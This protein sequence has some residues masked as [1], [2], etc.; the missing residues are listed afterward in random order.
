M[1][2]PGSDAPA[3]CADEGDAP[4]PCVGV[5]AA[6]VAAAVGDVTPSTPC[7]SLPPLLLRRPLP[8]P[9]AAS[10]PC[11]SSPSFLPRRLLFLSS[12]GA[13]ITTSMAEGLT[14]GGSRSPSPAS[15]LR[16]LSCCQASNASWSLPYRCLRTSLF[17]ARNALISSSLRCVKKG[18]RGALSA[19]DEAGPS[20]VAEYEGS[21]ETWIWSCCSRNCCLAS[22]LSSSRSSSS[23]FCRRL[24]CMK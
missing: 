15:L 6:A 19:S 18:S 5:A 2:V 11:F 7:T 12:D 1:G 16:V 22:F 8:S 13:S 3:C 24:F 14:F 10:S 21:I 23:T 20:A 17:H 9:S 4:S